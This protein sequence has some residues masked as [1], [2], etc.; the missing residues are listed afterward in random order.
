M[1]SVKT[2]NTLGHRENFKNTLLKVKM[3]PFLFFN[4]NANKPEIKNMSLSKIK[5]HHCPE[6]FLNINL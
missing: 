3:V 1:T 4:H 5:K 2:Y 6:N